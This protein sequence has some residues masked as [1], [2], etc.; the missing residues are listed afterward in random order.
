MQR[1][2]PYI[3]PTLLL[4]VFAVAYYPALSLLTAKWS[5]SEDYAHAFFVVPAIG[6]MIWLKRGCLVESPGASVVGSILVVLST[7]LYLISL[8]LQVPTLVFLATGATFISILVFIAG[9]RILKELAIP[10][11]LFFMIIPIPNQLLSTVTASL[12]LRISEAAEFV[13]RLFPIPLYREGNI[14]NI[15]DMSFQVV[16]AC[17]GV[18]SLIS[19]TTLS[20]ILGFFTLKRLWSSSL[21]FLFSIPVAIL[22]NII[23]I[24]LLV[25]AFHYFHLDLSIGTPHTTIGLVLFIFGLALL[26]AFQKVLELWETKNKNT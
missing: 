21:L 6:Y 14:L 3:L 26:F 25:L 2:Q 17:S 16:E 20:V 10:L 15:Q 19:M 13:I 18:R 1:I 8:R 11:L 24:V 7:L 4:A 23:R 9:F 12:Q 22:I 5:A